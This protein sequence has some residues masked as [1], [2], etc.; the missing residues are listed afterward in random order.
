MYG[1][2]PVP[3]PQKLPIC[4]MAEAMP[5]QGL[6]G[7]VVSHPSHKS[8]NVARVGHPASLRG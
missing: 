3:F 4:G 1:L 5:F 2:K 6:S 7:F 8:K